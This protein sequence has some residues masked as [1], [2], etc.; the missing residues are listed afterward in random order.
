M[1]STDS[2]ECGGS[3]CRETSDRLLQRDIEGASDVSAHLSNKPHNLVL[4]PLRLGQMGRVAALLE[5]ESLNVTGYLPLDCI[6]LG[7]R[8]V[9]VI[10]SLNS[11]NRAFDLA[12]H[13]LDAPTPELRVEPHFAPRREGGL[14][15]SVV[16][17]HLLY[18]P[19]TRR[20]LAEGLDLD[21]ALLFDEDVRSQQDQCFDP[22]LGG[23]CQSDRRT[24]RVSHEDRLMNVEPV[25]QHR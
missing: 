8:A 5:F 14:R 16:L 24:V 21:E 20:L 15:V 3:R 17:A 18:Q 4:C 10:E 7:H 23:M 22:V 2:G 25:E 6:D 19:S 1:Q 12:E 9:R 11:Q 13:I